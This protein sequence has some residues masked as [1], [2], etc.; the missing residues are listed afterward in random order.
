MLAVVSP[1]HI[2]GEELL[3]ADCPHE[4]ARG[5]P[6]RLLDPRLRQRKPGFPQLTQRRLVVRPFH[7]CIWLTVKTQRSMIR[8]LLVQDERLWS[9]LC[10]LRTKGHDQG[11]VSWGR[12]VMIK[13]MSIKGRKTM[14]KALSVQD[15][16]SWS[17]VC[18]LKDER[19]W[20]RLCHLRTEGHDQGCVLLALWIF[21]H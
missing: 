9:G 7:V 10:H 2:P 16:R 3:T 21:S 11:F 8:A 6:A 15:E 20:S 17:R 5:G 13:V 18:Q 19:P 1:N 4:R 14:I 12:K